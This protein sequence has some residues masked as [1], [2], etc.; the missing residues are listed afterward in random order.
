VPKCRKLI[1]KRTYNF[2]S[3]LLTFL[4]WAPILHRKF[5]LQGF[6]ICALEW[7]CQKHHFT[8][9]TPYFLNTSLTPTLFTPL[10]SHTRHRHEPRNPYICWVLFQYT[11]MHFNFQYVFHDTESRISTGILGQDLALLRTDITD[12]W[13]RNEYS[14]QL[15]YEV[16]ASGSALKSHIISA[17]YGCLQTSLFISIY[18][19][20]VGIISPSTGLIIANEAS[21]H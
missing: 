17:G 9:H 20:A 11:D 19:T 3:I 1:V 7:W 21:H 5:Q 16:G 8:S 15:D 4:F 13:L 12:C 6:W 18:Q 10:T 2:Q 14:V